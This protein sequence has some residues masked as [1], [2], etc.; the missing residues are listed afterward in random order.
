M[1]SAFLPHDADR[2]VVDQ[3]AAEMRAAELTARLAALAEA[4]QPSRA[5][6]VNGR[7]HSQAVGTSMRLQ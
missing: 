7:R 5:A 2:S 3:L 4:L 1:T 6:G